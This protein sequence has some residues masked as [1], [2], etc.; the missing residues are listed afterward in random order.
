ML[1]LVA[2]A[3]KPPITKQSPKKAVIKYA[4]FTFLLS[5]VSNHCSESFDGLPL[6]HHL[7]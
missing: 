4:G 5:S 6:R 7:G 2:Q 3:Y 1:G